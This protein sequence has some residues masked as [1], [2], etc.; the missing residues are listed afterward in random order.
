MSPR[1][2]AWCTFGRCTY[3]YESN[4]GIVS[5]YSA[6]HNKRVD[7]YVILHAHLV[8]P[9]I[10]ILAGV[11]ASVQSICKERLLRSITEAKWRL[12]SITCTNIQQYKLNRQKFGDR[13]L[14]RSLGKSLKIENHSCVY[15]YTILLNKCFLVL[16]NSAGQQLISLVLHGVENKMHVHLS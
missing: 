14:W 7:F 12:F 2:G 11:T 10:V 13:R 9:I 16:K 3:L 5:M 1:R 6:I 8:W 4:S 15:F